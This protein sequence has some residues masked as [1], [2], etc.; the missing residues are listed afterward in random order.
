[1][2]SRPEPLELFAACL[3]G[4]EPLLAGELQALGAAP[5][6]MAGGVEFAADVDLLRR[7]HLWLGTA[8][9]VLLRCGAFHCRSLGELQRKTALLPWARW[10]VPGAPVRVHATAR[11]SRL[12][13]TGAIAERVTNGIA[14]A[15]GTPP[16]AAGADDH[17]DDAVVV[18]V[19]FLDDAA[20]LSIDTAAT[21][22]HRRG[23]R[24]A[25]AKAPLREDLAHAL[26]LAAECRRGTPVLDPFCGSGT[27][28]IEA[29]AIATGL[30]PGRLRP[31]PL[32]GTA[33]ADDGHWSTLVADAVAAATPAAPILAGDRDRGA[34][35]AARDNAE[36]AG[37]TGS[38]E[39]VCAPFSAVAWLEHPETAPPDLLV[40]TNPPFGLRVSSGNP[41]GNLYQS[42]GHRL[43]SLAGARVALLAH[44]RRL[45]R[46]TGIEL[47]TAFATRHGGLP[48]TTLIGRIGSPPLT[49]DDVAT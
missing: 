48:V 37:V 14:D 43:G 8:S 6:P 30:P 9:H 38:I 17:D 49:R 39:F 16:A 29:A 26:L 41:L 19:R 10:L 22:L 12:Y 35:A 25:T 46:R 2:S 33:L 3:P 47:R 21:P 20:T 36:R 45:A 42:L 31:A 23:Y 11:K 5:R 32:R 7:A 13:H 24:L 40:A 27:I 44:D 4:L 18:H 28:A 15:L 1:M 34:I